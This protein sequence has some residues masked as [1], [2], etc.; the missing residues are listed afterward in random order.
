MSL[1]TELK[2]RNVIRVAIAYLIVGWLLAQVSTTLEAALNLPLWFDTLIVTI[3]LIGF[4]IAL[5]ISWVYELTPEGIKKEKN[6]KADET[7]LHETSKKLNYIT[8]IAALAVLGMFVWQQMNPQVDSRLHGNDLELLKGNDENNTT[9]NPTQTVTQSEQPE[10]TLTLGVAVL[11]FANM[12]EDPNNAFFASGVYEDVLTYLSRIVQWRVISRTSMEK[13]AERGMEITAIGK[14]LDVSHVLEGSVRRAGDSVRVTV[15]LIDA[16]NDE[17]IWAENY[18]RKL[19]DIFAIQ[20]EIAEKIAQ[21]LKTKLTPEQHQLIATAPTDNIQAYD[22]FIKAREL[23]RVWRNADGFR[24]QIPLLEQAITL[25]PKFAEAQVLLVQSY[26]RMFWT[27]SD[28]HGIYRP[29]AEALKN[30]ILADYPNSYY[31]YA[32]QGYYAYTVEFNYQSALEQLQMALL[33]RPD[34]NTLLNYIGASYKRLGKFEL[35]LATNMKLLS[36]DPESAISADEL[37]R[38]LM[39]ANRKDEAFAQ[40]KSNVKNF[41]ESIFS[42][43]DLARLYFEHFGDVA[44]YLNLIEKLPTTIMDSHS[45][46]F[47]LT[48][49]KNN[50][51]EIV[52]TLEKFQTDEEPINDAGIDLQIAELFNLNGDKEKS[53]QRAKKA[54]QAFNKQA[55]N[56]AN[57]DNNRNSVLYYLQ[58][59]YVSCLAND[60]ASYDQSAEKYH[61][62]NNSEFISKYW[63]ELNYS[64]AIAACGD[65]EKAWK[66]LSSQLGQ[67]MSI[68]TEWSLALDPLHQHYFSE[69]PEYQAMVKRLNENKANQ[70]TLE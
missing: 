34:N 18:D 60:Q 29:K 40:A 11:P 62:I 24:E 65:T 52:S 43:M 68:I 44:N 30:Q 5:I 54:L 46:Y 39:L 33:E 41:P 25:D 51:A 70:E 56:N 32:A 14:H 37:T 10:N 50:M 64:L 48:A 57:S 61:S 15:Q 35:A 3:M 21:Q 19:E 49:N 67:P 16:S 45:L 36:L 6:I 7:I 63:Q 27:G 69:L 2:R 38:N 31:A 55:L 66:M 9:V 17:H 22:L 53:Q 4:P 26:G 23:S 47:R 42:Q 28:N 13:I 59:M 58:M 1:F 20:T 8:I 12:S